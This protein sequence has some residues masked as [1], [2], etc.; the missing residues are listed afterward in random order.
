MKHKLIFFTLTLSITFCQWPGS[1]S[2]DKMPAIGILTGVV[3]DSSSSQP[4]E[5]ASISLVSSRSNEL[6]TGGLSDD[7]G[8][9]NIR[10]IPL[11]KYFAVVEF[12][13]YSK[14]QISPINLFPGEGGGIEKDLGIIMLRISSVNLAEVEVLGESQFI[15]TIDKQV[16]TVGK[17]LASTGGSGE[18]VLRQV[19]TVD[20]DID[21]NI[22]L[23][24]DAN[25]TILI[26]G[27]KVG[28]DRRTMVDN[29]QASMIQKVEVITNPSA[30]YDPDGVG[31]IIN[32]VLKRGAFE[33]FNGSI[34]LSAGQYNKNNIAGSLN[35][36][37]DKYNLF[38]NSSF[39]TGER[40]S[41]GLRQFT[42]NYNP[43]FVNSDGNDS[44]RLLFQDTENLRDS[45]NISF[46]F[47]GDYFP[48]KTSTLS[49][50]S[51]Y[52][53]KDQKANENIFW[54]EP[55]I[56][57]LLVNESES[58]NNWNHSLSYENKFNSQTK[59]LSGSID[60]N[61]SY[62]EEIESS[63]GLNNS[64]LDVQE[65]DA[66]VIILDYED[67]LFN[68]FDIET[69]VK[70]TLKGVQDKL[71]FLNQD[72]IYSYNEDIY[73]AYATLGYQFSERIGLKS[74]IRYEQ[75]KTLA[76]VTGDTV[77]STGVIHYVINTTIDSG[78]FDN[79]Y[80]KLYPSFFLSY[81]LTDRN[82]IQFGYSKRV[83]R[84]GLRSLN[85]FPNDLLDESRIRNG[86]PFV[87]P[88]FSDVAEINFS[89][90][91]RKINFNTG[92][93]YKLT[94]DAI[95]WW[96]RDEISYNGETYEVLTSG[97][98]E[99][100]ENLGGSVIINYRPMPLLSFMITNWWWSSKTT[101]GQY[102][103]D[104]TGTSLGM[105]NRG[106]FTLN[107]PKYARIEL[108]VGG[109][110]K[111][112]ITSGSIPASYGAD[113]GIEKSFLG[114]SLSMTL[115]VNDIFDSRKFILDTEQEYTDFT[116]LMYAER[117]RGRRTTSLN[118]RYNFGKQ[119]KKR[120]N[121]KG[122]GGRGGSGG[123]MDMDY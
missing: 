77:A 5:Y 98:A 116:Q 23:R 89:S 7:E 112:K 44:T 57:T 88:E 111:M 1:G 83:N 71:N 46:R 35:Y 15:Q 63:L 109:R 27:K 118:L 21:G 39:R 31:G 87:K 72:Y 38:G 101:G 2:G 17:N 43:S 65:N 30:K 82:Q 28:F 58:E 92:V 42:F 93:S 73:A 85:P 24:G 56:D 25:V 53:E 50:T 68:L 6:V 62:E 16:F 29:L 32:L 59:K 84:P 95:A 108:S 61:K 41:N 26:D 120:W 48:S 97:N 69:G 33:G 81:K 104:M 117:K 52:N 11:G 86:N 70:A 13:G 110:A 4:L 106:Q 103:D 47:G 79:P 122:Y 78:K 76:M 123:G 54:R 19:P 9:F 121:G 114:K 3:M 119:Q 20:V 22:T 51:T 75:V 66:S 90:N 96:D 100:A 49:Y 10:E 40:F 91:S 113:L 102:E 45:E 64:I 18:D 36:R 105:F 94:T 37:S 60:Y 99:K 55:S 12:V 34:S 74:G 115:K 8:R 80:N 14:K 107:I 67:K